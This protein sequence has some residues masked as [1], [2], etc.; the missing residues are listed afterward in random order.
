MTF[1]GWFHELHRASVVRESPR[2]DTLRLGEALGPPE[3]DGPVASGAS[4]PEKQQWRNDDGM[5]T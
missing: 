3:S 1:S 2:P 4:L 5:M